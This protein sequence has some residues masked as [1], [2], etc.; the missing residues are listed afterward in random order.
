MANTK[1]MTDKQLQNLLPPFKSGVYDNRQRKG[2]EKTKSIANIRKWAEE[3]LYKAV[4][5]EGEDKKALYEMIFNKLEKHIR[6]GNLKAIEMFFNYSG[7]KPIDKVENTNT[8]IETTDHD[9]QIIQEH[10]DQVKEDAG[11]K[12]VEDYKDSLEN[13]K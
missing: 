1:N 5:E 13:K 8:N 2:T 11:K 12:A 9:E 10:I 7:M 3:N 6:E 4:R